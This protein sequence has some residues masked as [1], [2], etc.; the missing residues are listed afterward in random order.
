MRCSAA[1]EAV[2]ER[3]AR[4]GD[5]DRGVRGRQQ[6]LPGGDLRDRSLDDATTAWR[7]TRSPTWRRRTSRSRQIDGWGT[8]LRYGSDA[9][10]NNY[11]IRSFGRDKAVDGST[12]CGTTTNFNNDIVYSNGTFVQWPE[13]TQF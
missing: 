1:S 12:V 9:P 2:D 11:A 13:G 4:S 3:H 5:C 10:G 8:F 7:R 6:R